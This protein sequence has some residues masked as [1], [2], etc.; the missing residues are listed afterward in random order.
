M[1]H[2]VKLISAICFTILFT[3]ADL[4]A[5]EI[6]DVVAAGDLNKVK[7][8]LEADPNQLESKDNNGNT[9]LMI[10][11]RTLQVE[12]ANYLIDKSANVNAIGDGGMTPLFCFPYD[13]EAPFDLVKRLVEKG[14]DINAKLWLNRNWTVL[15]NFVIAGNIKVVKLLIDHGADPDIRDIEG[16]PLQMAIHHIRNEEMAVFLVE[17]GAKLQ[18]FSF[19]NTD[20]HLAA[21]WG[22]ADLVRVLI[23]H[24]ANVNAM[25]EYDRTP[26]YYATSLGHRKAAEALIASG[27]DKSAI[28][29]T[30][31]GKAL[32]LT[33]PLKEGEAYLWYLAPN[34][35]PNTGYAVKTRNNLLIFDP[36]WISE[37]P[38]AGLANGF[39]N[40]NKLAGQKITV[41]I[42]Y[43]NNLP[44]LPGLVKQIPGINFVLSLKPGVSDEENNDMSTYRLA[45]ANE[46]FSIEGI[47]VH[48]IPAASRLF[49]SREGL[50]YLVEADGLKIFHA[51]LHFSDNNSSNV[52]KF[53]KEIDFLN[54]F[55]PIDIAIL[56]IKGR[57]LESFAYEPYLYL[58]DQLSP[59]AIYLIGEEL[60]TEEHLKCIEVLSA[61]DVPIYYPE[62]GIAIG[63][64]FH[65]LAPESHDF[66]DLYGDYLGQTPPGDT[67]MVFARGIVSTNDLE[68]SPAIFSTDGSEVYWVSVRL[69]GP[70]N[71]EALNRVMTMQRKNGR[72]TVPQ[73]SPYN[74]TALSSDGHFG[75]FRSL[76]DMD[77][78]VVEKQNDNWVNPKCL[79][80][81]KKYPELKL[82]A[83]PSIANSGTLYFV[84]NAEGLKTQNNYGIY[85]TEITKGEYIKPELLP[86]RINLPPFLNWTPFIASDESYLI[87]SSNRDGELGEGD[88]YI[89]F[90]DISTN[91]WYDPINMG[92]PINT[93]AQERLP[94]VT[95]DGKYLFF[96]RWTPE[97]NQDVYWVSAKIINRLREQENILK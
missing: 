21:I 92:E 20:L 67:P 75:Y 83:N 46:S 93:R 55:G 4:K 94:G 29:E 57:H 53:H 9:P 28:V 96:T 76:E 89:S 36:R 8:L 48:T 23:N 63:E 32:Q 6:H 38:E 40:P 10:A 58:I 27:A 26:L 16:T 86:R 78:W 80:L 18:E 7:A 70:D 50:G 33:E 1:Y 14:A 77:M 88:L 82:A 19:G 54:P 51:G 47:Q 49:G 42:G 52:A 43:Q 34:G 39:I 90:H 74:I 62:G 72:W 69:P 24:S 30:N 35:S 66:T 71:S 87:F 37:S 11:C 68:H 59:K 12:I 22:F 61:R 44:N 15:V 91:T 31:Y 65:Y 13:K 81:V 56:P 97:H 79:N 3:T 60:V 73:V 41:L 2:L 5:G 95:P 25:N 45:K 17:Y 85:R 84:G 64:R